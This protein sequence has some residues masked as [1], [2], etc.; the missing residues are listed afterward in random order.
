MKF[1]RKKPLKETQPLKK[2]PF[3]NELVQE[4]VLTAL[5]WLR[6]KSIQKKPASK[7]SS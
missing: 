1:F 2:V 5:G 3:L 6:K 4:R 7:S